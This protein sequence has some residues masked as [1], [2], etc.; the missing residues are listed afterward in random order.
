MSVCAG[1]TGWVIDES[2]LGDGASGVLEFMLPLSVLPDWSKEKGPGCPFR[3]LS[4]PRLAAAFPRGKAAGPGCICAGGCSLSTVL[5][6]WFLFPSGTE[7]RFSQ[8]SAD[9]MTTTTNKSQALQLGI[10]GFRKSSTKKR[11]AQL[12]SSVTSGFVLFIAFWLAFPCQANWNRN[13]LCAT[14]SKHYHYI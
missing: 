6:L 12:Q 5:S 10:N 9:V 7:S 2:H 13:Y 14:Q 3:G 8:Q 11:Q 4:H 1:R